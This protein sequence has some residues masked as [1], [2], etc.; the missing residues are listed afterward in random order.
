MIFI[1]VTNP[2]RKLRQLVVNHQNAVWNL[3]GGVIPALSALIAIPNLIHYLGYELFAVTSLLLT[4]ALFFH[5][6]DFGIGRAMSFYFP[7][8]INQCATESRELLHSGLLIAVSFSIIVGCG[9]YYASPYIAGKWLKLSA[10][11]VPSVSNAMQ[12]AAFGVFPS[13]IS[14]ALRGVLEGRSEFNYANLG[15]ILSGS[16]VFIAPLFAIAVGKES[17]ES[18]SISIVLS[19]YLVL[20]FFI[21][22]VRRGIAFFVGQVSL[23]Q[24][25]AI[26]KYSAWAACSGFL[27]T[28]FVYGDRFIVARYLSPE[29]L[30]IYTVSQDILIRMLLIP[31]AMALALMPVLS[32]GSLNKKEVSHLYQLHSRKINRISLLLVLLSLVFFYPGFYLWL[33]HDFVQNAAPVILI[34]IL[35]ILFCAMCQL[36]LVYA[37]ATGAPHVIAAMYGMEA[38]LYLAVAPSVF[39][40][41]GIMGATAVW[42]IRLAIEFVALNLI[43]KRL[44]K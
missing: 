14:S 1:E 42:T 31:W 6:Y 19:R 4:L 3:A 11:L 18:I 33:G 39:K 2:F 41:Y 30:S 23:R 26:F 34:Q 36:P 16:L 44:M 27:S 12:I 25:R 8:N 24:L 35:G 32:D 22:F 20:L 28:M 17:L 38:L 21:F 40:E 7:R 5:V 10:Q 37:Y 29:N 15:K 43:A 13:V 9:L